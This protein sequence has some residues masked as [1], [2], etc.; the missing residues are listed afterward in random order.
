MSSPI[1]LLPDIKPGDQVKHF[2]HS[3]TEILTV[4][5]VGKVWI[6]TTD[7]QHFSRKRGVAQYGGTFI[8]AM[9]GQ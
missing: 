4:K 3:A 9:G 5:K 8:V 7:G 1:D 6:Q 2:G